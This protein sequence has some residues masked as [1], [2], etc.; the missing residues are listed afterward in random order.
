MTTILFWVEHGAS[1]HV[2]TDFLG[3]WNC[4]KFLLKEHGRVQPQEQFARA[5]IHGHGLGGWKGQ[6]RHWVSSCSACHLSGCPRGSRGL[7]TKMWQSCALWQPF[8]LA[9]W[10]SQCQ[11][12][13]SGGQVSIF[14]ARGVPRLVSVP[15]IFF[16]FMAIHFMNWWVAERFDA[17]PWCERSMDFSTARR[18]RRKQCIFRFQCLLNALP[19][20]DT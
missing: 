17:L 12:Y 15:V 8:R 5:A 13:V 14:C 18:I 9:R 4:S 2:E 16:D 3:L 7:Q 1:F 11:I 20:L 6:R 10:S 19:I